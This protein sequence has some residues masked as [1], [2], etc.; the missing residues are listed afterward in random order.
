VQSQ[1]PAYGWYNCNVDAGF[2]NELGMTTTGWCFRDYMGQFV[3][4]G[5]SWIQ[6]MCSIIEGEAIVL[7]E[8]MK[9]L[10]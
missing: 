7:L 5:T 9:E 4:D 1:K 10:N 6:G 2:Y 8:V 3:M